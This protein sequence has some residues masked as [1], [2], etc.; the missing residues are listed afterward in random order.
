MPVFV[1]MWERLLAVWR[2]V[3]YAV[4][5][6]ASELGRG[7]GGRRLTDAPRQLGMA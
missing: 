3:L 2:G 1:A 6:P 4:E 5:R 7:E